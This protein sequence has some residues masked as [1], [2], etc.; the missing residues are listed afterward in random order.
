MDTSDGDPSKRDQDNLDL[1]LAK[2]TQTI[3]DEAIRLD[4]REIN[5]L[6]SAKY[7]LLDWF[8]RNIRNRRMLVEL[9]MTHKQTD[10]AEGPLLCRGPFHDGRPARATRRRV[11][12]TGERKTVEMFECE[13]CDDERAMLSFERGEPW[14]DEV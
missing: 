7:R 8:L 4:R 14:G 1:T 5:M 10:D 3:V 9:I 6:L 12:Y 2:E 11:I 13:T